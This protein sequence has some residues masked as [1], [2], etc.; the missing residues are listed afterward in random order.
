MTEIMEE[1]ISIDDEIPIET[2][3]QTPIPEIEIEENQKD[4]KSSYPT[5]QIQ[6]VKDIQEAE[7]L[8]QLRETKKNSK[9]DQEEEEK[10]VE[11]IL[12]EKSQNQ[13]IINQI[14]E[15]EKINKIDQN[16]SQET[17]NQESTHSQIQ[18]NQEEKFQI[19]TEEN[20][21]SIRNKN[22]EQEEKFQTQTEENTASIRNK[23]EEQKFPQAFEKENE[24]S[25]QT[26]NQS[27]RV[28]HSKLKDSLINETR[29]NSIPSN[30]EEKSTIE[31]IP[32]SLLSH[33]EIEDKQP[34]IWLNR[35][36][37]EILN[38]LHSNNKSE[39]FLHSN[40]LPKQEVEAFQKISANS[41]QSIL[42]AI[43]QIRQEEGK[44]LLHKIA[45]MYGL[46]IQILN[47]S[48]APETVPTSFN[49]TSTTIFDQTASRKRQHNFS[50][51]K[52]VRKKRRGEFNEI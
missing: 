1:V 19:Q 46:K 45:S 44:L 8:Q 21:A 36:I 18:G 37:E 12:P 9:K 43:E 11:T 27:G 24:F 5:P 40:V 6:E 10:G 52:Q 47:Q 26:F 51:S 23:N 39:M 32:S 29:L 38:P 15:T 35:P 7:E 13:E 17:P 22:E 20:T 41:S 3:I 4:S 31:V 34:V 14:P 50:N 33:S 42:K 28:V 16:P 30:F 49:P 2:G 25:E 48:N